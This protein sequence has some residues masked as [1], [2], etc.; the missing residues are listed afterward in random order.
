MN[1]L[2][3]RFFKDEFRARYPD[4]TPGAPAPAQPAPAQPVPARPVAAASTDSVREIPRNSVEKAIGNLGAWITSLA[5][6][7]DKFGI[8][9]K[10]PG[11]DAEFNPTLKDI[12]VGEL[13]RVL[14]DISYGFY[15]VSGKG[16]T[17]GLKSDAAELL[18]L[19]VLIAPAARSLVKGAIKVAE[20]IVPG[21]ISGGL[22]AQRGAVGLDTSYKNTPDSLMGYKKNGPQKSS[23][24]T[25]YRHY[26][27]LKL[28]TDKGDVF[29][30]AVP[31]L[32]KSHALERAI[33]N[34]DDGVTIKRISRDE[35]LKIDPELVRSVDL[36]IKEKLSRSAA[37]RVINYDADGRRIRGTK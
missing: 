16:V 13:G 28:T 4:F 35:A 9:I 17:T 20:D 6:Q 27:F 23:G 29:Y 3:D 36:E 24:E 15:P 33:R 34:W 11:T 12:T 32:N 30:D 25:N 21:P 37:D 7:L 31:G 19:P 22:K 14:E 2:E 8:K 26:E 10:V 18:N 5:E 1:E